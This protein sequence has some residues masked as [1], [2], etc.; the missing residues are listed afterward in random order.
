LQS[1]C[2]GK[3][4]PYRSVSAGHTGAA[5]IGRMNNAKQNDK[6]MPHRLALA[7]VCVCAAWLAA[8][9]GTPQLAP[10]GP[11]EPAAGGTH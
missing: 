1:A 9:C 8:G 2:H 11:M 5:T 6:C 10:P 7:C 3:L 4:A